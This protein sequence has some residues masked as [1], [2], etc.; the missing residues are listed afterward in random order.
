[1]ACRHLGSKICWATSNKLLSTLAATE[2]AS[3][4]L[5]GASPTASAN[6]IITAMCA[7]VT[8]LET[9]IGDFKDMTDIETVMSEKYRQRLNSAKARNCGSILRCTGDSAANR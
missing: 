5:D 9:M 7:A 6:A 8:K 4:T 1:M 3:K 2:T